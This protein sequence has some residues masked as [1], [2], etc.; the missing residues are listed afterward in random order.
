MFRE[1]NP[2]T[3]A[4]LDYETRALMYDTSGAFGNFEALDNDYHMLIPTQP[5]R[6]L[7]EDIRLGWMNDWQIA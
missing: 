5:C 3:D 2:A 7:L 4:R 6:P 1:Y